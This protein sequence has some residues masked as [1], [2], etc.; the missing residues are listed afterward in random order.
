MCC[1]VD[2]KNHETVKDG[3]CHHCS[4]HVGEPDTPEMTNEEKL[5]LIKEINDACQP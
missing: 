1:A 2:G 3:Y 5:V 4:R